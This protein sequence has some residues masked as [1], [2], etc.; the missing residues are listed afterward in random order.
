VGAA[1][2]YVPGLVQ[3]GT[4]TVALGLALGA[5]RWAVLVALTLI[6]GLSDRSF[7]LALIGAH[8][9]LLVAIP[10]LFLCESDLDQ[11]LTV[12]VRG[13]VAT[14]AVPKSASPALESDV[15]RTT[16]WKGSLLPE[17]SIKY[18]IEGLPRKFFAGLSRI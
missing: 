8:A 12:F 11:R 6:E 3:G 17:L 1:L 10:L 9:R 7:F 4:N 2:P 14:E 18:P 13:I 16:C 5:S 15:A